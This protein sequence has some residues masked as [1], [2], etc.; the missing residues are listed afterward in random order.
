MVLVCG[1]EA[2][3]DVE[4]ACV[5][6]MG[7]GD[8]G[9]AARTGVVVVCVWA[10]VGACVGAPVGTWVGEAVGACVDWYSGRS[11][12]TQQPRPWMHALLPR[13]NSPQHSRSPQQSG[14]A[15]Q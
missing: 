6:L 11:G 14:S 12:F 15:S 3:A 9:V 7:G 1:S 5:D 2:E 10:G 13:Q 8:V 4:V